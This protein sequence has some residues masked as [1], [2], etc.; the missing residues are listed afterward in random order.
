MPDTG[1]VRHEWRA[2]GTCS[3]LSPLQYFELIQKA[4]GKITIPPPYH[5]PERVLR[6]SSSTIERRFAEASR[7]AQHGAIHVKCSGERLTEVRFCFTK[8][9]EPRSC[10]QAV[11]ECRAN[12]ILMEPVR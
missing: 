10:S 7:I 3:E 11:G 12:P 4:R 6:T 9:L 1:L 2:H 8:Q 5:A